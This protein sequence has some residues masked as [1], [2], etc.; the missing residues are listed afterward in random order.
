MTTLGDFSFSFPPF[1][2]A[3][4]L[5]SSLTNL[6]E[7]KQFHAIGEAVLAFIQSQ[8]APCFLLPTIASLFHEVEK[9]GVF[10]EYSIN[11]FELWLNQFSKLSDAE[12]LEVRGKIVG[13]SIPRDA[14]Q[15]YFPIGMGKQYS[16]SHYVCAHSSPDLDTTVASFWGWLDAFGARVSKGLHIWNIPGG[17]P[18]NLVEIAFLFDA[19]FGAH[20]FDV[21]TK[22]KSSLSITGVDLL[23]Q[24]GMKKKHLSE[25][26]MSA[27]HE[28][29]HSAVVLV[30]ENGYYLGDWRNIDVETVRQIVMSLN[31]CLRWL[32]SKFHVELIALF[33]QD[34]VRKEVVPES[35]KKLLGHTLKESDPAKE[36]TPKHSKDLH[37]YLTKVLSVDEGLDATF[38]DFAEA[39][40][41]K[42]IV[43]FSR[44]FDALEG[45]EAGD[46]YDHSG[47]L[48]LSR[49]QLFAKLQVIV[50]ELSDAFKT[51]R[52]YV[53]SLDVAFAVK[54][55]VLGLAPQSLSHRTELEEIRS[56]ME[57]YSHLTVNYSLDNGKK[58]PL[59]VV[60][61]TDL[62]PKT[63][64]TVTLRDFCNRNEVKIPNYLEIISVVDHHKVDITTNSPLT[65]H[66]S[67]AQSA[68]ACVAR[69]AF[70]I[71]DT[72]SRSGLSEET[73][74][75]QFET[76]KNEAMSEQ[77]LRLQLKLLKKQMA[78][79]SVDIQREKLE[80]LQFVYAILDD[81]DLLTKVSRSDVETV[82]EL[83]NRLK[84]L[85]V[86]K[87][88]EV[89]PREELRGDVKEAA[90]KLLQNED[91]YSLYSKVYASKESAVE[92]NIGKCLSGDY[93]AFF[94]DAK[95]LNVCNRV[96]Q[97]KLFAK[98]FPHFEK[99]RNELIT[100]W[101]EKAE[102]I[103]SNA[104]DIDF[105]MHMIST[106]ASAEEMHAGGTFEYK[107]QDEVWFWIPNTERGLD[108]MESFLSSFTEVM[109]PYKASMTLEIQGNSKC[110]TRAFSEKFFTL[111]MTKSEGKKEV[112]ILRFPPGTLNSRKSKIAPHLPL[113]TT[114]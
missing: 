28:R 27:D 59:G 6:P 114:S 36:F 22:T 80:Y 16:G 71:N 83:L 69:L 108:H 98:N 88:V 70:E 33:A 8:E 3:E 23:T 106:V 109:R 101:V 81:T 42:G 29:K 67:D 76:V 37:E 24:E 97:T 66:I 44:A 95:V 2:N 62:I 107:H 9:Q 75:Q 30:D 35:V 53:D 100:I 104:E 94:S 92:E 72:Y 34:E 48:T 74:S 46:S 47:Q 73:I 25:P 103:C 40:E 21:V 86:G 51:L 90:K 19:V 18:K 4:A 113:L 38:K 43:S 91:F 41:T 11:S 52:Q 85:Q 102:E 14:Y 87:V 7:D 96:S 65:A 13:K 17:A 89:V 84:T 31:G 49:S 68:N 5:L 50:A 32:E 20:F 39:M 82:A 93:A 111:P 54:T 57:G 64:G 79:T 63:L 77:N 26:A 78:Q 99:N 60:Y 56:R 112:A 55:D 61:S 110:L 58:M 105:H 12:N 10:P 1:P 15:L 45:L